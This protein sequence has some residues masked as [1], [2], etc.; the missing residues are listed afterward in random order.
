MI[1]KKVIYSK[2][3]FMQEKHKANQRVQ[4]REKRKIKK[5][6]NYK[7]RAKEL[8]IKNKER[9]KEHRDKNH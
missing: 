8:I 6:I 3:Y 7:E 2:N 5:K 4:K 1:S 9:A